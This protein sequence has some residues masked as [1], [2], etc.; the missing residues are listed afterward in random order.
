MD[1]QLYI[2]GVCKTR[3][4]P[5]VEERKHDS[6]NCNILHRITLQ[7]ISCSLYSTKEAAICYYQYTSV[8]Q[9]A[10]MQQNTS[11]DATKFKPHS[12]H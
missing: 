3:L 2:L 11:G 4:V 6:T 8:T 7:C 1:T 10:S 9:V 12:K 5:G